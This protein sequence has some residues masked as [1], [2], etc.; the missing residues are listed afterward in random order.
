MNARENGVEVALSNDLD[1]ALAEADLVTAADILYDRENLP[2]LAR[3]QAAGAVLLADSR[4]PD[5]NPP[6]YRLLGEWQ[7]CTWPDLGESR[8]YNGVRLFASEP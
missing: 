4:V 2:L 8:E 1:S 7:S 6:G 3:F 5:L